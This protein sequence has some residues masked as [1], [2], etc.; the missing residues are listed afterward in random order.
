MD[1][2]SPRTEGSFADQD[3]LLDSFAEMLDLHI[4]YLYKYHPL[5]GPDNSLQSMLGTAVSREEFER[6]LVSAADS[7]AYGSL[8]DEEISELIAARE[9]FV[10]RYRISAEEGVDFP[11]MRVGVMFGLDFFQLAVVLTLFCCELY[12]KYEMLFIFLQDDITKK[13]V[14]VETAVRLWAYPGDKLSE[15]FA[16]FSEDCVLMKYLCRAGEGSVGRR[17]LLLSKSVTDYFFG[18]SPTGYEYFRPTDAVPP[19][20]INQQITELAVNAVRSPQAQK[21]AMLYISGRHGSGRH[22]TVKHCAKKNRES[23]LFISAELFRREEKPSRVFA[24]AVCRCVL[25]NCALCICDF[26]QILENAASLTELSSAIQENI[27]HLGSHIYVISEK[28]WHDPY[29]SKDIVKLDIEINDTDEA[30]RLTLWKHFMAEHDFA[31]D[32]SAEELAAKFRF[33]PGQ[34]SEAVSRAKELTRISGEQPISSETLHRSCYDRAINGLGSLASEIKPAYGWEDIVLPAA[35]ADTLKQAYSYMKYRHTVYNEWGFGKKAAYGKGL[36]MLFSGPPGTGKTMAAQ[37]I[38]NQFKM[39]LY[40]VQI[41]QIVS[42][43]IGETEKNLSM[44]FTEAKNADC[45]LFFDETDALFG[46]RTEVKDSH[47]RHANIETA[48]LLQQ[49]EEYDGVVLMATNLIQNIDEAFMRRINFVVYFP[50]PD[51]ETRKL[52]WKKLLDTKAPIAEDVDF[53]FLAEGFRL[54]GGSIKN[55]VISAAFNAAAE[56]KPIGMKHLLT[57]IITEQRKNN[58][59]VLKEELRQYAYLVP[60]I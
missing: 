44:I 4:F 45:I 50:F 30:Q 11:L 59:V 1:M 6:F 29:L 18:F 38:A 7:A 15:Y 35:E 8:T 33:T 47:D 19:I 49:M 5:V 39:R 42:K 56:D 51:V 24:D 14:S 28:K 3:E 16:A 54:A 41:S 32:I 53:D 48:Y 31:E 58:I 34:I 13:T 27:R 2:D 52:L 23:V 43:Y 36:S 26:E 46:K 37:I 60:N 20:Y 21:T 55:C 22:F 9:Y 40:K 57:G 12:K 17:Q 10:G 25:E